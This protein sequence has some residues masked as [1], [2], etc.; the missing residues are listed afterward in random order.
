MANRQN[1]FLLKRSN[2]PGKIPSPGDIKL[3]EVALNTADAILYASGTTANS[4]LPIGWDRIS[5]TG[6]TVTGNFIINGGINTNTISATTYLNLP[7]IESVGDYLPLSGGTVTGDT[8]FTSGLTIDIAQFNTATTQG[9]AVGRLVWNNTDGTLDLGLKGGSVTLQ[10][11]Q[12]QLA[13]VVNKTSPLIDLL[14]SNY[15]VVVISGA[16]GQRVSVKLAKADNDLN[17]AGT[18][19]VVTETILKNQEGFITT[20]G[21][22]RE[23]NTTGSLQGETWNDGD[24]LYLSPTVFGQMTNIKPIAPQHLVVVGYVEYAHAIHGKIFVKVDNGYELDELHNVQITGTTKGGSSL[25]Y[26][27]STSVWEDAPIVWTIELINA[28]SVDVYAPYNLSIDVKTNILNSPTI[29][30]YDDDVLYTLGNTIAIGS[31]ITIV[32]TSI[33]VTNLTLT[34]I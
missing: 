19:G 14:E 5:R 30:I 33:G 8:F 13:R 29:T 20:N 15:Q 12:E 23:I 3:G 18:L 21:Q 10:I 26:N 2:V 7:N 28:L 9:G 4:I 27:T 24:V 1:T 31:K 22:V 34:K 11:G 6:D 17:S 32:A 16:Q 25:T